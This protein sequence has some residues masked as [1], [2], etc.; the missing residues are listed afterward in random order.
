MTAVPILLT[1]VPGVLVDLA[2]PEWAVANRTWAQQMH[3]PRYARADM[4]R[5]SGFFAR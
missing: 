1:E 4:M 2:K 5:L 3:D